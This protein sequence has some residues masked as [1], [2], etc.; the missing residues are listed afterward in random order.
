MGNRLWDGLRRRF[1]AAYPFPPPAVA[2]PADAAAV[3]AALVAF[4]AQDEPRFRTHFLRGMPL[5]AQPEERERF[6]LFA[7]AGL[8]Q[9]VLAGGHRPCVHVFPLRG[10]M[11]ATDL[12]TRRELDQVF[13]LMFEQA[14]IVQ[15]MDVRPGDRVLELCLGSGVNSLFAADAASR[16]V[17]VDVNPRALGFARFNAALNPSRTPIDAR[18]GSLYAPLAA[19]ETF[20]VVLVNPPFE[21]VPPGS[22]HFLHSHGGWDGLDVVREILAGAPARL[23]PGGRFEMFTWSPGGD[24]SVLV[25]DLAQA[26]FPGRRIEVHLA[27]SAPLDDRIAAFRDAP[28]FAAWRARLV[29]AGFT[30]VAGVFLRATPEGPPGIEMIDRTDTVEAARQTAR[31]WLE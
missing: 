4:L 23:R 13:P 2:S 18:L 14:Y 29:A 22:A 8:V 5:V 15:T 1:A 6:A 3:K 19:D 27:D 30:R 25:A 31:A 12:R 7:R 24:A 11:I 28:G 26:A 9:P 16:V 10:A 20:D 21:P 17:G